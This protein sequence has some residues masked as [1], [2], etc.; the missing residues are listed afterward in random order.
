VSLAEIDEASALRLDWL[1]AI[2][3]AV[4]EVAAEQQKDALRRARRQAG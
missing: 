4:H 2:D 1:L 3:D